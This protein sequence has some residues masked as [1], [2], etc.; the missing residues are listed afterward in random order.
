MDEVSNKR[1]TTMAADIA[2]GLSYLADQKYVHRDVAARNCLVNDSRT[3][4]L[5]D[6]ARK[7]VLS[8]IF[9]CPFL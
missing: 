1:L 4:K 8:P 7:V 3:V 2:D 5:A 6:S 9:F